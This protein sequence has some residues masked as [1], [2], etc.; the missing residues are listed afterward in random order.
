MSPPLWWP[1][2]RC[3]RPSRLSAAWHHVAVCQIGAAFAG[4]EIRCLDLTQPVAIKVGSEVEP[5]MPHGV[6]AEDVT[7]Y[8]AVGWPKRRKA[9][10]LLHV[11]GN[12]KPPERLDLPLG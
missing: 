5:V 1:F 4:I 6:V 12:L 2:L 7:L 9:E 11:L 3:G 10:S 8:R